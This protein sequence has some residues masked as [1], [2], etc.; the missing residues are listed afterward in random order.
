MA[1]GIL[2]R[3]GFQQV[4]SLAGGG[5]AWIEAGLPVIEAQQNPTA[6][7]AVKREIRLAERISPADLKRLLMDL[8][9]TFQLVD[10]RPAAQF[11]DYS[12]PESQNVDIADILNDPVYLTG[13][14]PL[15]IVDRDGTLAMMVGGILSQKTQRNVK[16]LYG[17]LAA[18]WSDQRTQRGSAAGSGIRP[19]I[20]RGGAGP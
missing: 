1:V 4:A 17:G 10:I 13:A 19:D 3:A 7:N 2:E 18:Y 16:V 5:E 8:P 6:A 20:G 15:V 12:L 11:A 9:D 14:G